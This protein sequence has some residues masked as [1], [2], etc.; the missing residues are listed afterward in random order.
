MP[1]SRRL[2]AL[3]LAAVAL[4]ALLLAGCGGSGSTSGGSSGRLN[5]V[6]AED[7]WGSIAR[8]AWRRQSGGDGHHHQPGR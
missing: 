6:A 7:F 8:T 4:L 1:S 5:V 2:A 3:P